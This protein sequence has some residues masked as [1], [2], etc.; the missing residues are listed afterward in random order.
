MAERGKAK[1]KKA[2]NNGPCLLG[3]HNV[4]ADRRLSCTL[5]L[6][7]LC[8]AAPSRDFFS[9]RGNGPIRFPNFVNYYL[10]KFKVLCVDFGLITLG[11]K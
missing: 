4:G 3:S 2:W 5:V 7:V 1:H 9:Y 6:G 10:L 8:H 11:T